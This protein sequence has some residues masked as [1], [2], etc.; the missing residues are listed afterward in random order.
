M[1]NLS[2]ENRP[3]ISNHWFTVAVVIFSAKSGKSKKQ[4]TAP[5]LENIVNAEVV[6][7]TTYV[8]IFIKI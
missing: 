4:E 3:G 8:I 5:D 1:I 6:R 2:L 7:N